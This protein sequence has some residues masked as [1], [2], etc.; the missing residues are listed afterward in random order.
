M[1]NEPV[2]VQDLITLSYEQKPI[3]FQGALNS[4]LLDRVA[5]AIDDRKIEVA[6]FMFNPQEEE[7][8]EME[9]ETEDETEVEIESEPEQEL[10]QDQE[11]I[12]DGETA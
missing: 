4:L 3:E 1:D 11:E 10:E 12:T 5:K 9:A 6:Q 2:T 7:P 8:E